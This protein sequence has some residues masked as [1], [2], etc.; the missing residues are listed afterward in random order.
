MKKILMYSV[1][2]DEQPAIDDWVAA[3]DIRSEERRVG[4]EC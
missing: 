4:K 3:N 1:R 2:P